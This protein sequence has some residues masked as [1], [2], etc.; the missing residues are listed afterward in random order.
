MSRSRPLAAL[1]TVGVLGI[2]T[3]GVG[4]G[5]SFTDAVHTSQVITAG[6]MNMTITGPAGTATSADG[7]TVTLP[8]PSPVGSTFETQKITLR[9]T[10]SGNVP[11]HA[12]RIGMAE[13]H[14]HDDAHSNALADQMNVCIQSTDDSGGPWTEGDGPLKAAVALGVVQN[15]TLLNP[16]QSLTVSMTFY[17][18]KDSA[19]CRPIHSDGTNTR[20]A[21]DGYLGGAYT[22]P[23]ALTEAAQGGV[24]VP[25]LS[26]SF[27]G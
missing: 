20:T 25:T 18:G 1:L 2:A 10:N 11:A 15:P 13:S 6:T 24:V 3:I 22:T 16:G 26:F 12:V 19:N 7:K 8:A 21:W 27:E 23:A 5:A 9:V 4:A 14:N 17:A